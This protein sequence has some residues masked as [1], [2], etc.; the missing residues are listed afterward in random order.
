[1]YDLED[2]EAE[3]ET[4]IKEEYESFPRQLMAK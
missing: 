3:F 2:T 4:K 1:M